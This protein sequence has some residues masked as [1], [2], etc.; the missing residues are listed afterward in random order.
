MK[1]ILSL[2]LVIAVVVVAGFGV[3][4]AAARFE[5]EHNEPDECNNPFD[6]ASFVVDLCTRRGAEPVSA[7][8]LQ[9]S[10]CTGTCSDGAAI[11]GDCELFRRPER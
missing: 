8:Y 4:R 9:E 1:R 5:I 6:C 3:Q 2:S 11:G 10:M 7:T